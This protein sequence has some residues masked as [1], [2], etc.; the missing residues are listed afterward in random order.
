MFNY[1]LRR[2]KKINVLMMEDNEKDLFSKKK[3]EDSKKEK[4]K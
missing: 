4:F 3:I 2:S 1:L